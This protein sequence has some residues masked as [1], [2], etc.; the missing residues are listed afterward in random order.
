M[1]DTEKVKEAYRLLRSVNDE[2]TRCFTVAWNIPPSNISAG[3][4]MIVEQLL[5]NYDYLAVRDAFLEARANKAE[6][7]SYVRTVAKNL[8]EKRAV[9][10]NLELHREI[11][12][13][14]K[15]NFYSKEVHG[16]LVDMVNKMSINNGEN[17]D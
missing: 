3:D 6:K 11:K 7:L 9:K 5:K 1:T 17:N 10:A 4:R 8:H 12:K 15:Q 2:I 14:E 16:S 13:E